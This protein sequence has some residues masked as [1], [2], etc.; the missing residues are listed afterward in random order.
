MKHYLLKTIFLALFV[1][2]GQKAFAILVDGIYYNLDSSQGTATVTYKDYNYN[3]YS[4]TVTIPESISYNGKTYSVTSIGIYAFYNN[5]GLTS[6]TIP[7]SVTN[8]GSSAFSGCSNLT[9]VTLNS[10]FIV[11]VNRNSDSSLKNVF[12]SQ[13]TKYIIGDEVTSIGRSAFYGCSGLTSVTIP[14]SVTSISND[15]FSGCSGLTSVTIPN[16]VTSI[17]DFAFYEC[18]GLTSVTIPNSVTSIGRLA[19][20]GCS[21]LTSVTIPNSVTS[22]GRLAFSGCSGLTEICSLIT[23]PF[24]IDPNC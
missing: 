20:I 12:G 17:G 21:G 22:I 14:N 13:V 4:G 7:N 24:A 6:V 11:A 16:S 2:A 18:S 9:T 1:F 8:I 15:A 5:S 23:E 19:F 10:K 3:S